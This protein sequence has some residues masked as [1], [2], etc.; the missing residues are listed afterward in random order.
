MTFGLTSVVVRGDVIAFTGRR[1]LDC[2]RE[3]LGQAAPQPCSALGGRHVSASHHVDVSARG[4]AAQ[5]NRVTSGLSRYRPWALLQ[6]GLS[7]SWESD[8]T[9]ALPQSPW[10]GR[11]GTWALPPRPLSTSAGPA[12]LGVMGTRSGRLSRAGA[13]VLRPGAAVGIGCLVPPP[14]SRPAQLLAPWCA[15]QGATDQP[16]VHPRPLHARRPCLP[17]EAASLF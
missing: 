15:A 7:P 4:A 3:R 11:S 1:I 5:R 16:C 9:T 2:M 10:D 12:S 13:G 14:L 17:A 6:S 8:E